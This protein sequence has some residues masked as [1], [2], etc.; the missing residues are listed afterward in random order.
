MRNKKIKVI[1]FDADDTLWVNEPYYKEIERDFCLM[2]ADYLSEK[3]TLET[4]LQTESRNLEWYGYG[5]KGFGLSLIETAIL[6]SEGKVT[7]PVIESI[8]LKIKDLLARKI[9]LIDGVLPILPL[10]KSHYKLVIATKGD[11]LDQERKLQK[12]E[13]LPYFDRIE[14]MSDKKEND[15]H[16]LLKNLEITPDEFLMVGNSLKS[17]ILPV[18]SIGGNAVYIPYYLNW[19]YESAENHQNVSFPTLNKISELPSLLL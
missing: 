10:L 2:M 4:L 3:E 8:I 5:A 1:G 15:Y 9:E 18:L 17:D 16:Q 11:L 7:V 12:S 14:I 19:Q 6:I 13:L